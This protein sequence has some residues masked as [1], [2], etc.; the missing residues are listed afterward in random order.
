MEE[1]KKVKELV[2]VALTKLREQVRWLSLPSLSSLFSSLPVYHF[3]R[4]LRSES[5]TSTQSK[6]PSPSSLQPTFE[7][8]SSRTSLPPFV[9]ASGRRSELSSRVTQTSTPGRRRFEE[10]FI[11]YGNGRGFLSLENTF[12]ASFSFLLPSFLSHLSTL[13]YNL[14]ALPFDLM[15]SSYS[16]QTETS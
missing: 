11:R 13:T 4:L 5:T 2:Q 10:R 8:S 3:L 6:P 16:D 1:S 14:I 12:D 9:S 7:I 15:L